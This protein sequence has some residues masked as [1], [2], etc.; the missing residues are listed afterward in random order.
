MVKRIIGDKREIRNLQ[1]FRL[2]P[3][4]LIKVPVV[5]TVG[6]DHTE[7]CFKKDIGVFQG[8]SC[9]F[10]T[11]DESI[12]TPFKYVIFQTL[13]W[14]EVEASMSM[15]GDHVLFNIFCDSLQTK[16]LNLLNLNLSAAVVGVS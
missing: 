3:Y 12:I 14:G 5:Y 15:Y 2:C 13:A 6:I 7:I 1:D 4:T 16:L 10:Y 8:K 11:F 9:G